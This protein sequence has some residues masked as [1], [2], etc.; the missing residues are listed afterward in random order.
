MC[1]RNRSCLRVE[2]HTGN[3]DRPHEKNARRLHTPA[4][5]VR[6]CSGNLT[7]LVPHGMR[8]R[9]IRWRYRE[10][11]DRYVLTDRAAVHFGQGLDEA[12]PNEA[13]QTVELTL[14]DRATSERH[15]GDYTAD[16]PRYTLDPG[17]TVEV[18][19][20]RTG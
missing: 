18:V 6:I 17:S 2:Y 4:E 10:L 11:H 15:L 9:F 14:L 16:N 5:F 20:T 1:C 8:V 3:D 13:I 12:S 7:S 19:G